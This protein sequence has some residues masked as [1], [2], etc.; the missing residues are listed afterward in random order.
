MA[1]DDHTR[2]HGG[3]RNPGHVPTAALKSC[4]VRLSFGQKS[5]LAVALL[6]VALIASS[7]GAAARAADPAP[8]AW[9]ATGDPFSLSFSIAGVPVVAEASRVNGQN[10]R[11]GY[12]LANGSFH[13]VTYLLG[14]TAI[15]DGTAYR[16][17]TDEPGRT[18]TVEVVRTDTG[19]RVSFTLNP[20]SDVVKTFEAFAATADEHFMGGGERPYPLDLRTRSLAIKASYDCHNTMPAPFYLSSAGYGLSL[21]TAAVASFA[22]P[23]ALL[24]SQCGGGSEP[25]CPLTAALQIVQVCAKTSALSYDVFSGTPEQIVSAYSATVGRPQ[26]PP[27]GQFELI[28]W[29]D[30]Y[31][32]AAQVLEDATKLHALG[33][34]IGWVQLDNPWETRACYGSL[35]FDKTQFPDPV[36]MIAQLHKENVR[37]MLWISP[38]VRKE[39]C[40]PTTLYASSALFGSGPSAWTIDLTDPTAL[41]TY[42]SRLTAL[43]ALGV[44]GFKADR[45]E[46]IDLEGASLAGGPGVSLG[47]LYPLQYAQTIADVIRKA[48]KKATFTT[49]FRAGAPGSSATV[50]GFWAGDQVGSF[51]GLAEAIHDGLSAGVAG[52]STWGSDTG[53]YGSACES[54]ELFARWAQFSAVSP[55]FEVGGAG[56]NATFWDW[57]EP[58]VSLFRAAAVLHYELFPYLYDLTVHAHVTGVPVLR[59]LALEYPNDPTAWQQDLEALVGSNLLAAP[60]TIAAAAGGVAQQTVYLPQGRWVDLNTGVTMTGGTTP[61]VRPTPLNQLPLY[62]RS[63]TAIPF[64]ARDPQI[65]PTPWPVDALQMP[66]RGGW[67]Y[68]P[69]QGSFATKSTSYGTFAAT[70]RAKTVT[71]KLAGAPQQTQVLLPGVNPAAIRIDG[72]LVRAKTLRALRSATTGWGSTSTPFPSI[73]LKLAPRGGKATVQLL[74][75]NTP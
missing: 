19:A 22:F 30:V 8:I 21:R 40:P 29:R 44:D 31:T 38:L 63:G 42:E 54:A 45:G 51:G 68:A 16:L 3:D 12:A 25:S 61:F 74:L 55:V 70:V 52:Y 36:G 64:A 27:T 53:G 15:A 46:E 9:S 4:V 6:A 28:K 1:A 11:L 5:T 34:P 41:A 58:T 2:T 43:I 32:G 75:R 13:S 20:S 73:V 48:G 23:G 7:G 24:Q 14:S 60:V 50:P 66:G 69:A 18:A 47:N 72:Q 10:A 26:M 67:M 56:P 59:P 37:L 62:L 49:I 35:T 65:W 33:I 57:G 39:Y 71:L 17:A